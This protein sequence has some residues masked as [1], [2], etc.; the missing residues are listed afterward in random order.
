VRLDNVIRV[1]ESAF[2]AGVVVLE[3]VVEGLAEEV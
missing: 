3:I 1:L 2:L